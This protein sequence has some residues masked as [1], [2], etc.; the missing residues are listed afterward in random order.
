MKALRA[1]Q[2]SLGVVRWWMAIAIRHAV[3]RLTGRPA[4]PP[5]SLGPKAILRFA[6]DR[7]LLDRWHKLGPVYKVLWSRK[8]TVC[9][10]GFERGRR[11]LSAHGAALQPR[12]LELDSFVPKGFLRRMRGADHHHFRA[13]FLEAFRLDLPET[14]VRSVLRAELIDLARRHVTAAAT[15]E[16]LAISL[17]R[18]ALRTLLLVC[19]GLSPG[20]STFAELE[21]RFSELKAWE[22]PRTVEQYG[23]YDSLRAIVGL[24]VRSLPESSTATGDTVVARLARGRLG[25]ALDDTTI[26]NLIYMIDTGRYDLRGLFRWVIS[27]SAIIRTS[28]TMCDRHE[29]KPAPSRR[30]RKHVCSRHCGSTRRKH[31]AAT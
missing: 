7:F 15:P 16:E 14:G 22:Y 10:V 30:W 31:W 25:P 13:G 3:A 21:E 12:S 26:G 24:I 23:A 11:L 27:T 9:V 17:D 5:G 4:L 20:H 1:L 18:A 8:L 19:F 6:D 28:S 29:S 2:A